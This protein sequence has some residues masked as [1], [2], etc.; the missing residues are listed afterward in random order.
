MRM[1]L[2]KTNRG[3]ARPLKANKGQARPLQCKQTVFGWYLEQ[4]WLWIFSKSQCPEWGQPQWLAKNWM[5]KVYLGIAQFFLMKLQEG[6][7]CPSGLVRR[8]PDGLQFWLQ[9]TMLKVAPVSTKYLSFV[10]SSVR[11]INPTLTGKCIAVA[12]A[13]VGMAA[14]PEVA[15]RLISFQTKHR[16]KHTCELCRRCSCEIYKCHCQGFEMNRNQGGKVDDF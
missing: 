10:N 14:E 7:G 9:G 3:R 16:A 2:L 8:G 4:Q 12:V 15:W 13:C 6:I 1:R 5:W 11:K